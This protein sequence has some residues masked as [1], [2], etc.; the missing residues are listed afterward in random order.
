MHSLVSTGQNQSHIL[1]YVNLLWQLLN[2][3][4][5]QKI[6]MELLVEVL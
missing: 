5:G 6:Q 4:H 2:D 3:V 1:F